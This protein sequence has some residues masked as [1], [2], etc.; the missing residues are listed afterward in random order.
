MN[1]RGPTLGIKI[2]L[3]HRQRVLSQNLTGV[4]SGVVRLNKTWVG[5]WA[6]GRGVRPRRSS[7]R[8]ARP[9][10]GHRQ[11]GGEP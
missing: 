1:W 8:P 5:G 10:A 2:F 3:S 6:P 9:R 7:A 4:V 11:A